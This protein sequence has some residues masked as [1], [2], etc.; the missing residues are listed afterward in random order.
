M[1]RISREKFEHILSKL[2]VGETWNV[3]TL[4]ENGAR[5]GGYQLR[6]AEHDGLI[7]CNGFAPFPTDNGSNDGAVWDYFTQTLKRWPRGKT[8]SFTYDFKEMKG[9]LTEEQALKIATMML[10]AADYRGSSLYLPALHIGS[11][12]EENT[13]MIASALTAIFKEIG[14]K[15]GSEQ[16][17]VNAGWGCVH[18]LSLFIGEDAVNHVRK[19]YGTAPIYTDRKG[20]QLTLYRGVYAGGTERTI[21][22]VYVDAYKR[23][24]WNASTEKMDAM[25]RRHEQELERYYYNDYRPVN[26]GRL[27]AERQNR[28]RIKDYN[29]RKDTFCH[30]IGQRRVKLFLNRLVKDGDAVARMYRIALEIEGVNLAAKKALMKYHSDYHSYDR[31]EAMLRE[32]MDVCREQ[33]VRYGQQRSTAPAATHVIYFDLPGC[34][35][36]SFHT[37]MREAGTLPAYDGEWDGKRCSTMSKLEAAI[38]KR[39]ENELREKYSIND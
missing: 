3:Q 25:I 5:G 24:E 31:K 9:V 22:T 23:T 16:V 13:Q 2:P 12:V 34:E 27:K 30:G 33:G 18:G 38:W 36:I 39:Y 1:K 11:N 29:E 4:T 21:N 20:Q 26:E 37:N 8:P 6:R 7:Y 10:Y 17:E 35:Q 32:L 14:L 15:K 19:V 28:E